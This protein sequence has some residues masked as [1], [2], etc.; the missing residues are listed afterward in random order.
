VKPKNFVYVSGV[1][2]AIDFGG[3]KEFSVGTDGMP[4]AQV[5]EDDL[6]YTGGFESPELSSRTRCTNSQKEV[7]VTPKADI[8]AI[9]IMLYQM[10]LGPFVE[11]AKKRGQIIYYEKMP[12]LEIPVKMMIKTNRYVALEFNKI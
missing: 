1:L 4:A 8:W 2:K 6:I 11:D 7:V 3:A 12:G 10:V 5:H 9:G